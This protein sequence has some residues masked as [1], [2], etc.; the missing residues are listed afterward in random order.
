MIL[1]GHLGVRVMS[2]FQKGQVPN[3]ECSNPMEIINIK[4]EQQYGGQKVALCPSVV[5][6]GK[7][8]LLVDCGYEGSLALTSDEL[9]KKGI[10]IKDVT[11]FIISHDDNDHVGGLYELKT[12]NPAA[13]VYASKIEGPYVSGQQKSLRLQ[14]AEDMFDSLPANYREWGLQ[15]QNELKSIRRVPVDETFDYDATFQKGIRIVNTPGHTPGHISI[16]D[17]AKK[18]LIANDAVV[19]DHGELEIANPQFA[20]DLKQAVESVKKLS[21]LDID[22]LYCYHGGVVEKDIKGKLHSLLKKYQ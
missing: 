18:I 21:L 7:E 12:A 17:P 16:Y 1:S 14:Q 19:V 6:I 10:S 4:I 15:F 5:R 9:R 2:W 3:F 20:L 13:K 8:I 22:T 11:G